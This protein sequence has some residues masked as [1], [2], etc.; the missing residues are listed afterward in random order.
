MVENAE[1]LR[2]SRGNV[3]S[4]MT[5]NEKETILHAERCLNCGL[6]CYKKELN[7]EKMISSEEKIEQDK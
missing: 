5:F 1:K 3:D 7:L 4:I 6:I 2:A